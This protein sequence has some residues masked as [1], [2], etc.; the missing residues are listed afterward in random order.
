MSNRKSCN[1][2]QQ[3][4]KLS[5]NTRH[6]LLHNHALHLSTTL[7]FLILIISMLLPQKRDMKCF[8]AYN[9]TKHFIKRSVIFW[10]TRHNHTLVL[11]V[12]NWL[13]LAVLLLRLLCVCYW[14]LLIFCL[15]YPSLYWRSIYV[16]LLCGI[17]VYV[18]KCHVVAIQV[19]LVF[20][21]CAQYR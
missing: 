11:H 16:W 4:I 1:I 9:A 5:Q 6:T 19:K 15:P 20:Y 17:C 21:V 18:I 12:L 3:K 14:L 7:F 13:T 8:Y 10:Y 2:Q